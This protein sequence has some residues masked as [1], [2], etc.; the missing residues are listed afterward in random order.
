MTTN[1]HDIN[2]LRARK[3]EQAAQEALDY[4]LNLPPTITP[5]QCIKGRE[6]LGW[7]AQALAFRSGVSVTAITQ[8]EAGTRKLLDITRQA[9]AY[10]LEGEG[11][12]LIPGLKPSRSDDCVGATL[13]PRLR[14]DAHMIE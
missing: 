1:V 10:A 13:N 7:T 14:K 12:L 11:L 9:L 5:Q 2:E 8:Y 4:F 3:K 6:M